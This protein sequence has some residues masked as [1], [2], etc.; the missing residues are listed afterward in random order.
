METRIELWNAL[1]LFGSIQG[2]GLSASL[3]LRKNG[4]TR[5]N[6]ILGFLILIIAID[7]FTIFL[8]MTNYIIHLP[9][10]FEAITE[11]KKHKKKLLSEFS[12]ITHRSLNWL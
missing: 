6:R 4:N 12:D 5:A 11:L 9:H 10:L 3:I 1:I 2:M 8:Q 7:M